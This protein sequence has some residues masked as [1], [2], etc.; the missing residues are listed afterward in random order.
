MA[1][2]DLIKISKERVEKHKKER[3][4]LSKANNQGMV[5]TIVDYTNEK[6]ILVEFEDG[7][8]RKAT[9]GNFQ[10]G[11][12]RN[13]NYKKPAINSKKA[14]RLGQISHSHDG[15]DM[16]LVEYI[17]ACDV[18][19]EFLDEY[20]GRV[21]TD[22]KRFI[23]GE[24]AN[25]YKPGRF[26]EI[27][28]NEYSTKVSK[29]S[30]EKIKEYNTWRGILHRVFDNKQNCY[31]NVKI[32]DEWM[33]FP[34]FI[35][36]LKSQPNYEKWKEGGANEWNI[37]KDI[38]SPLNDKKYS[39]ETCCLVPT[40]INLSVVDVTHNHKTNDLPVGVQRCGEK[41]YY[42]NRKEEQNIYF[43]SI[44]EAEKHYKEYKK[45]YRIEIATKAF[46]NNDITERCYKA[47]IDDNFM[48][49]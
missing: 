7:Y 16:Q 39:P 42:N 18:I 49:R 20:H 36:W 13:P 6:E 17:N 47:L 46:E 44:D 34:N 1:I 27:T 15:Y 38:L 24:V 4:G 29:G 21:H 2:G 37:D 25:P 19:V 32:C 33:F 8:R 45:E 43:D 28:G 9:F 5:M 26:G 48:Y 12:V 11:Q 22:Y 14:E 41:Y 30:D 31:D 35:K 40:Y 3:I 23:E 10:L